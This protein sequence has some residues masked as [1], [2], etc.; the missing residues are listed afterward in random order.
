MLHQ[1]CCIAL[2]P[3]VASALLLSLQVR[4]I[5]APLAYCVALSVAVGV[6]HNLADVSAAAFSND[7]LHNTKSL[8]CMEHS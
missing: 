5:G 6:Y 3:R 4:W 1:A 2:R 8:G 7:A